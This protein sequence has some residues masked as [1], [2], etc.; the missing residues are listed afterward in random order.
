MAVFPATTYK[1]STEYYNWDW[2]RNDSSAYA[3]APDDS[4]ITFQFLTREEAASVHRVEAW[5]TP[6]E[7]TVG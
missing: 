5:L 3:I 4:K 7:S 1:S 2:K 6:P